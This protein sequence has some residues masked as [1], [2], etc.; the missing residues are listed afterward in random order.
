MFCTNLI[1]GQVDDRFVI[2]LNLDCV[3][4]VMRRAGVSTP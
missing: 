2:S 1:D 3:K 4:N